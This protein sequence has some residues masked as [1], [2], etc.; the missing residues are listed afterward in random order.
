MLAEWFLFLSVKRSGNKVAVYSKFNIHHPR[1]SSVFSST[2][3]NYSPLDSL[4]GWW[5]WTE[6][7]V[8]QYCLTQSLGNYFNL[9]ALIR[10]PSNASG[11]SLTHLR[12]LK[13]YVY[14]EGPLCVW[15]AFKTSISEYCHR[16][17]L[18]PGGLWSADSRYFELTVHFLQIQIR[19]TEIVL[20]AQ[21]LGTVKGIWPNKQ[22][23]KVVRTC[24]QIKGTVCSDNS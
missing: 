5:W 11:W 3:G 23:R 19:R 8:C 18:P 2:A 10:N 15:W 6:G 14:T 7:S 1:H 22:K 20:V 13:L 16:L 12:P 17:L 24:C 4:H 21:H 9:N